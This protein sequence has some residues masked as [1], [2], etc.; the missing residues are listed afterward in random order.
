[1][2]QCKHLIFRTLY[3]KQ[4]PCCILL[5]EKGYKAPENYEIMPD[6]YCKKGKCNDFVPVVLTVW[7]YMKERRSVIV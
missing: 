6:R 4:I 7:E 5:E 3:G 1:M 2:I